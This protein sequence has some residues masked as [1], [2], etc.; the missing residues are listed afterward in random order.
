MICTTQP[1]ARGVVNGEW[2]RGVGDRSGARFYHFTGNFFFSK[3]Q[4]HKIFTYKNGQGKH[5][6]ME[7]LHVV[8]SMPNFF[9]YRQ[10]CCS[11]SISPLTSLFHGF[12]FPETRSKKKHK[13]QKA[14]QSTPIPFRRSCSITQTTFSAN[15]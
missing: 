13:N 8:F 4:K 10:P 7:G 9:L 14:I 15:R 12:P 2:R 3:N 5:E 6:G 1:L 11:P